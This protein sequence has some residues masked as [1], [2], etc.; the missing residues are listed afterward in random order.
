M[1][2]FICCSKH[3]YSEIPPIQAKLEDMGHIITL[4]N[5]YDNPM[6]EYEI[7]HESK[8]AHIKWKGDMFRQSK[9]T[10]KMNDAILVLNFMKKGIPNYIGGATFIE[11]YEAFD[12]KKGIFLYNPI[13]EG[14]LQ[15]EIKGFNPTLI[16]GNLERIV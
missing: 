1:D 7:Q 14:M 16:E 12:M 4:P 9:R 10:I 11:M 15:D 5:S 2:L 6:L 8:D 3:F 13:P